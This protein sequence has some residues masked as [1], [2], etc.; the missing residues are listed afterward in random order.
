MGC[1][2]ASASRPTWTRSA[3][4]ATP[5]R[6]GYDSVWVTDSQMI[7]SDCYAV[8]A[9]AAQATRRR[10]GWARAPP[11]AARAFRRCRWRRWPP[12][13]QLAPGPRAPRH[14]HRQHR[15]AHDGPAPDADRRLRRVPGVLAGLLRGEVVDYTLPATACGRSGCSPTTRVPRPRA[16][17]PA[18]RLGLRSAGRRAGRRARRRARLRH[19]RAACR[20]AEALGHARVAPR[21]AGRQLDRLP[22]LRA[23]QRGAARARRGGRILAARRAHGRAQRHG[24]RLLLLRRGAASAASIRRASCGRSWKRYCALVEQTPP[25]HR[26]FRTHEFHYTYLHPGEARADRRQPDPRHLPGGDGR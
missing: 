22:Q 4:S 1:S 19:P 23:H 20:C 7:F 8:L 12:L 5:R 3:S 11:S 9:L 17:D 16:E 14:R 10:S 24:Q 21:R 6:L 18:V 2:S 25:P 26:R 13:N 15:H